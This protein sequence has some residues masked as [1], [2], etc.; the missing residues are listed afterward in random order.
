V[1]FLRK[2]LEALPWTL[3]NG[4]ALCW[5]M[6]GFS[7][8]L[9]IVFEFPF[10]IVLF[11]H[12]PKWLVKSLK[13]SLAVQTISYMLLFGWFWMLSDPSL[14]TRNEIVDFSSMSPPQNILI[15]FI[16][17]DDGNVYSGTLDKADWKMLYDVKSGNPKDRL[18]VRPSA[19]DSGRW[20]LVVELA[21]RL[22]KD[23]GEFM[24]QESFA[25]E[26]VPITM[27]RTIV[28]VGRLVDAKDSSWEFRTSY[29]PIWGLYGTQEDSKRRL[30]VSFYTPFGLWAVGNATQLPSDQVL[31]Q[32]REN[33]ICLFDPNTRRLALVAKG[34][35]PIAV[36]REDQESN[37]IESNAGGVEGI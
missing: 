14:Y 26:A 9:T 15:Y 30:H 17:E 16:S 1:F 20:D 27:R 33:Q 13:G 31:F 28:H 11:R 29:W 36:I 2:I 6:V 3:H 8:L 12:D 4:W 5:V 19:S 37:L 34:R 22:R 25:S 24:V 35:C 18:Q 21:R 7:Y 32:L 23:A 10:M